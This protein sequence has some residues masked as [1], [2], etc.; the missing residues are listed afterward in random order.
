MTSQ[1]RALIAAALF[2]PALLQAGDF[3]WKL[4]GLEGEL[5]TNVRA[6]LSAVPDDI[7][8]RGRYR[9][10]VRTGVREALQALGYY[11]P[12]I[13]F[14]WEEP[15]Q[16]EGEGEAA[17]KGP[18]VLKVTV[19]PEE[20]V[21]I[22]GVSVELRGDAAEDPA[23]RRLLRQA[24][25]EGDVLH[26]G[27]YETFKS[28]LV[29]LGMS[30]GYFDG[31]LTKSQLGVSVE[32]KKAFWTFVYESGTRYRVG[33]VH[34]EGS[35]IRGEML[36]NL[37][38]FKP[39]ENYR[40]DAVADFNRR[41]S[42]TGWF[43]TVMVTPD[44]TR[45]E[46]TT[47]KV[48]KETK[49][50]EKPA[51]AAPDVKKAEESSGPAADSGKAPKPSETA[52]NP[53][54]T[55]AKRLA[56]VKKTAGPSSARASSPEDGRFRTRTAAD[57]PIYGDPLFARSRPI[58]ESARRAKPEEKAPAA[59]AAPQASEK[60]EAVSA[61]RPV[62]AARAVQMPEAAQAAQANETAETA[63]TAQA[64]QT[65]ETMRTV[66]TTQA[67]ES[68]QAART[69][70]TAQTAEAPQAAETTE[71]PR[72]DAG[73][74]EASAALSPEAA[75]DGEIEKI[76]K[77]VPLNAVL[78]PRSANSVEVGAGFSSD[79][80]PRLKLN[81][82]KPW[83]NDKGHS[84][85]ATTN[86]STYEPLLDM[87]YKIPLQSSPNDEYFLI[88]G[89]YKHTDVND[90]ESDATT[91]AISRYWNLPS[92]WQRAVSLHW[93]LENFTQGLTDDTVMLIYPGISFSRTRS[94]G[95]TLPMWGDSLRFGVD[96]SNTAWGS[97]ADFIA[98]NAQGTIIRS[99]QHSHRF[100]GRANFGWI[101]TDDFEKV[102]PDLRF[103]AGG[104]RSVRGYDYKKISPRDDSGDLTGAERLLTLSAEYQF[105]I[106]G[107]W[108][109]A[110]FVDTG[111]AVNDFSNSDF[112]TG[113][114][115]GIRW[116]SPIG[117]IKFD[118]ARPVG[119]SH[120]NSLA[121][122]IGLGPEL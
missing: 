24:P 90:T 87:A 102:P 45:V 35:H 2:V 63:R 94:R 80:G 115:V 75:A 1:H 10:R 106:S 74:F 41:L 111:E 56:S 81:W 73:G 83:V 36:E 99:L 78:S 31:K 49:K 5:D 59:G 9:T 50:E 32:Q 34:F 88:Q 13:T 95:R 103:F 39:G 11:E 108:W 61:G 62:E 68:T 58:F 43:G 118:I 3:A 52:V 42:S 70:K 67:S 17:K 89:G 30:R 6:R 120:E 117:P 84:F 107:R 66:Q 55:Q 96:V 27:A 65:A 85:T 76:V 69:A 14:A 86:I 53:S 4:E 64:A 19:S 105:R 97:D 119:D 116:I 113:A 33:D 48:K 20:P 101:E 71:T 109:G 121:F 40:A 114:G 57:N 21:R 47:E 72:T 91:L 15:S 44:F 79:V 23:F 60:A 46:T 93:E 98:F 16:T 7:T 26:H 104:D 110:V 22:A 37:V 54:E 112:K 82:V 28:N 38:P 92:G 77:T 8:S 29:E 122:Y 100:I 25:K 51:E 12:K 18:L